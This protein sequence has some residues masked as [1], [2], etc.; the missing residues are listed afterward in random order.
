MATAYHRDQAGAPELAYSTSASTVAQFTALKAVLTA[1]LVSGYGAQP[2]AGWELIGEGGNYIVLRNAVHSGYVCLTW[3]TGGVV[4]VYLSETY[5]GMSGDVMVGDGLKTGLAAANAKPQAFSAYLLVH[6]SGNSTWSMVA[7]GQ[8]FILNMQSNTSNSDPAS[9]GAWRGLTL[10][11]GNDSSGHFIAV[12][13]KLTTSPSSSGSGNDLFHAAALTSLK[14]PATGLLVDQGSMVAA[15]PA[16]PANTEPSQLSNSILLPPAVQLAKISWYGSGVF[17]GY[18]RGCCISSEFTFRTTVSLAAQSLGYPGGMS[19]R[20][21]GTPLDL[22]D[23]FSYFIRLASPADVP[24]FLLTD[25][26]EFW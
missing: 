25:N 17:A 22:G 2:A 11:V 16:L 3:V 1:C 7:D 26:P 20:T 14:N 21:A 5:S 24:F 4:R 23:G 9:S 8:T 10:Y 19:I 18:L 12:G 15:M 6:S 13:G